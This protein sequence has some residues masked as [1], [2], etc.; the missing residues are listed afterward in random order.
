MAYIGKSPTGTGVRSRYYYTAS[1]GETSLSGADDN[2]ST[3]SFSDGAYVDVYLNGV[4]L[5]AGTDYNTSTANTISGLSALTA[6]DIAEILV[7]DIFTV[8]DTVSAANGGT[9]SGDVLFGDN[10]KAQFGAG[11]DLQIYHDGSASY[12]SDQ[13][14]GNLKVLGTNIELKNAADTASYLVASNGGTVQLYNNG[15]KKLETS[16]TGVTVTGTVTATSFS[17]DGSNLTGITSSGAYDL[18]GEALTLDADGDTKITADTDDRVDFDVAGTA[19]VLQ[20][21]TTNLLHSNGRF[22]RDSTDYIHFTGAAINVYLDGNHRAQFASAGQLILDGEG[23][24]N[25]KVDVRQGS[26]KQWVSLEIIGAN[27]VRDSY[28]NTSISDVRTGLVQIVIG[29]NMNNAQFAVS[30]STEGTFENTTGA[31]GRTG[32]ASIQ[33]NGTFNTTTYELNHK[34]SNDF[35]FDSNRTGGVV[36]GDLA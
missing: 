27:A 23:G 33:K 7:Y 28:N 14:I 18:N 6:N 15:A 13:G 3:L 35:V 26:A 19:N 12:V 32:D 34:D 17:G 4:L 25:I 31:N 24:S 20:L 1:G 36:H 2:S 10:V 22:G 16:S 8:A 5:V 21:N 11:N 9:F 29:N 30:T